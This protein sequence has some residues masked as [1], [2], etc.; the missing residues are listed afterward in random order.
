MIEVDKNSYQYKLLYPMVERSKSFLSNEMGIKV[1]TDNPT[2]ITPEK[3]KLYKY[4]A[5]IGTAGSVDVILIMGYESELLLNLINTFLGGDHIEEN[6]LTEIRNSV[7]SEIIN[8]IVGNA[9][10][11][12]IDSSTIGITPPVMIHHEKVIETEDNK[13]FIYSSTLK[14]E[15]GDMS[16]A[17][18]EPKNLFIDILIFKEL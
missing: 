9:L 1:L 6:E 7:S 15:Y 2:I 14:T 8:I 17:I 3:L 5:M 12:P 4:S 11:N 13:T 18:V 10:I 16:I